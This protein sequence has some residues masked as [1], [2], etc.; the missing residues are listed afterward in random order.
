VI[1]LELWNS[2]PDDLKVI[3]QQVTMAYTNR[4]YQKGL[5][6]AGEVKAI[7]KEK[8]VTTYVPTEADMAKWNEAV[9]AYWDELAEKPHE[10]EALEMLKGFM[11]EM[12]YR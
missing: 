7:L 12:G 11:G 9:D 3:I 4:Y 5:Y 10:V 1:N 8:G 2:L 6:G